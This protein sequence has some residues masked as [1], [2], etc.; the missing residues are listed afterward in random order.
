MTT[1]ELF[2][3]F[4]LGLVVGV[5]ASGAA[6]FAGFGLARWWYRRRP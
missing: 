3:G 5:A 4:T 1:Q 2:A 6:T